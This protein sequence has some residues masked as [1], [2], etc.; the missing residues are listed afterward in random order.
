MGRLVIAALANMFHVTINIVHARQRDCTVS[1]TPHVDSQSNCELNLSLVM[2]YHFVGL[3]EQ[4]IVMPCDN[5]NPNI[6][7]HYNEQ[8]TPND[9]STSN[10]YNLDPEQISVSHGTEISVRVSCY[11]QQTNANDQPPI[12]SSNININDQT[13]LP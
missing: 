3:D 8:T 11:D 6:T 13:K 12:S 1:I 5:E 2:Q 10:L 9:Q 7:N 4:E